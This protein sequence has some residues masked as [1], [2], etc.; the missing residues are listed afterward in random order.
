ML[1]KENGRCETAVFASN[2]MENNKPFGEIIQRYDF[3][4]GPFKSQW[5]PRCVGGQPFSSRAPLCGSAAASIAVVG[6]QPFSKLVCF[7][8]IQNVLI[9]RV[10]LFPRMPWC[11]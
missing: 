9:D 3:R 4:Y 1:I 5:I 7:L 11:C 8:E 10:F 6:G 2:F